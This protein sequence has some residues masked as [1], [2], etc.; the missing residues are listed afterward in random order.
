M[1]VVRSGAAALTLVLILVGVVHSQS[2]APTF[3]QVTT[4]IVKPSMVAEYEDYVKKVAAAAAKVGQTQRVSVYQVTHGTRN[5]TY[6]SAARLQNWAAL[7][8][9]P[10][11]GEVM[12]KAHGD[13]D[14]QRLIKA[15]RSAI[16]SS[17]I[18]VHRYRPEAST[19]F[20]LVDPIPAYAQLIR[21]TVKPEGLQAYNEYVMKLKAAQE[22]T[23]NHPTAIRIATVQ[24]PAFV[25]STVQY[26]NKF[27]ERDSWPNPNEVLR[28]SL[29][30][31]E[32]TR[33]MESSSR[34]IAS[35]ET[36]TLRYR[37]DLSRG[38]TRTTSH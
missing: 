13:T 3:V 20:K 6:L 21:T 14:G 27:A 4:T 9:L 36:W 7:D 8:S 25:F 31:A 32:T 10:N 17:T 15:G 18:E 22:Q 26:F 12:I 37:A 24:G 28:K 35:R 5:Y 11:P 2:G 1:R 16:E 34:A 19:N 38:G 33:L 23:P 29:G 30:E